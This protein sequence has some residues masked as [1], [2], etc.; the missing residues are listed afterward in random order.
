MSNMPRSNNSL[1]EGKS[2]W[3]LPGLTAVLSLLIIGSIHVQSCAGES[4]S[5]MLFRLAA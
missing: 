3:F 5:N 1:I 2:E 4:A